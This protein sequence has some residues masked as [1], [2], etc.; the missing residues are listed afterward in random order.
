MIRLPVA[1]LLFVGCLLCPSQVRAQGSDDLEARLSALESRLAS[2]SEE[3]ATLKEEIARVGTALRARVSDKDGSALPA[4]QPVQERD[5][6]ADRTF[7][8][9]ILGVSRGF[10]GR[11]RAL[12][13][14]PEILVQ[15]RFATFP[16]PE[17]TSTD[18]APNFRISRLETRWAGRLADRFGAGVEIQYHPAPDGV[19]DRLVNDAFI[20][21][22]AAPALTIRAGQF[23]KPFG[24]DVQQPNAERESPERAMVAGYVFPGQRDRGV[25]AFGALDA[26]CTGCAGLTYYAAAVNGNRL[27]ADSNR[28]LNYLFRVRKAH[29]ALAYGASVQLGSQI[30][31]PGVAQTNDEHVFGADMQWVQGRFG[32]RAEF[33]HANRPSTLLAREPVFAP[34]FVEG[35]RVRTVG[36]SVVG[37]WSLT[38][39]SQAYVRYDRL[40]GDVVQLCPT[41]RDGTCKINAVNGGLR[42]RLGQFGYVG[43]DLQWKDRLSFNDDAVNTRLQVTST[44][45][46]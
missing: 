23:I 32:L 2:A 5:V 21:Y 35:A 20:E 7:R 10:E 8:A 26:L 39:D 33:V 18:Y 3:I 44:V 30:T 36:S 46:F 28:Q 24:F 45:V 31:P 42:R 15:S 38:A 13:A 9:Q 1:S 43:V 16:E 6:A 22:Y 14:R 11:S 34:A 17:A 37:V 27:F 4:P 40:A 41:E 25:M 12:S 19:S 29:R